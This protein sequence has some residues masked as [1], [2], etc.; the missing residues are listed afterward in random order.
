MVVKQ[1][2]TVEEFSEFSGCSVWTV[3]KKCQTGELPAIKA[4]KRWKV[5]AQEYV[6]RQL[7][8]ARAR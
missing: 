5:F 8:R 7:K 1:S 3:R 6:D 4:G 2:M